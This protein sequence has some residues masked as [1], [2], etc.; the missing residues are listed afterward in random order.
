MFAAFVRIRTIENDNKKK[1]LIKE[2]L[3]TV[4]MNLKLLWNKLRL[5][6]IGAKTTHKKLKCCIISGFIP[7]SK[8]IRDF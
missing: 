6:G 2:Q 3:I 4:I 7:G 1:N 8:V 5:L